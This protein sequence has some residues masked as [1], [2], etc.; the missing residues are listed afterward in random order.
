MTSMKLNV[1]TG[2]IV[3]QEDAEKEMNE[4]INTL[5]EELGKNHFDLFCEAIG[6]DLEHAKNLLDLNKFDYS[7]TYEQLLSK[8]KSGKTLEDMKDVYKLLEKSEIIF[9]AKIKKSAQK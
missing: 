9:K 8:W 4:H 7:V 2:D 5:S 3:N 6:F 1:V